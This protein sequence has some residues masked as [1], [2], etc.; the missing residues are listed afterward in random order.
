M[1]R[2]YCIAVALVFALAI[3]WR[4]PELDLR[5]MH[6]DEAV[7]AIKFGELWQKGSYKYDP[8]EYHGP[9][10]HYFTLPLAWLSSA[11]DFSQLSE[12]TLRLSPVLFSLFAIMFIWLLKEAIGKW[13]VVCATLFF[14]ISPIMVFY[15]RYFI[16]E[17][18]LI[19]FTTLLIAAGW[20]YYRNGKLLWAI[21][22]GAGLGLMYATK[23]TFVL[24]V[25]ALITATIIESIYSYYFCGAEKQACNEIDDTGCCGILEKFPFLRLIVKRVK[26]KHL[27]I[28]LF[29]ALAVSIPFFTSMF[30]NW[31]GIIDSART[32]FP[33][34]ERAGGKSPH[35]HPW[36]FYF[37]RLLWFK[38]PRNPVY[39]WSEGTILI[40]AIVGCY[41]GFNK[42]QYKEANINKGF[43]RFISFYSVVLAG[44]YSAISYKTPW[45]A[46]G[47]WS[48]IILL[49]GA[50][51]GGVFA[52]S[53]QT[54]GKAILGLLILAGAAHLSY[55][56]WMANYV[57]FAN[58][59]NPYV[60]SQ[61]VPDILRL[62]KV[63][64]G[65]SKV[66]P[67]G[68]K[69]VIKVI[70]PEHNYWPLPWYFRSFE[71]VG[72]YDKLPQDPYAPV[73]ICGSGINAEIDEKTNKEWLMV[74]LYE[75]RPRFYLEMY[76]EFKYWEKYVMGLPKQRDND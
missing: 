52:I 58:W 31:Q 66:H 13:G 48:G 24:A 15:S 51:A 50:G 14:A 12:K 60:Y 35:I 59:R 16:H 57:H 29:A 9:T 39:V 10:L 1:G 11:R 75:L 34:L 18:L 26:K 7:N 22:A 8:D 71:N 72:W 41:I 49:A 6:N 3:L 56:S 33:W 4:L 67:D 21:A 37:E 44:I 47:F 27:L 5:P 68:K 61:T 62:V 32:Y 70:A 74:G 20:K 23:E 19:C 64:E 65:V 25:A 45:C 43:I 42:T 73:V 54:W 63:V 69:M 53:K 55:L 30:S 36:Y 17:M 40:F 38:P 46:L 2:I 76:V 28:A